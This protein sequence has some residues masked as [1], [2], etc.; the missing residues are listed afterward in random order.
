[1]SDQHLL[2]YLTWLGP[3]E[4]ERYQRFIRPQRQRQ[5]LLGRIL[6]R[7][8]LGQTLNVSP[9]DIPLS[10]RPGSAP[11]LHGAE[12]KPHFSLSHSGDWVACALSEQ[13]PVGLDIEVLNPQRDLLAL[14]EQALDEDETA[15]IWGLQ[16]EA[17]VKMFYACWSRKEALYKLTS[18]DASASGQHCVNLSHPDISIVL[19]SASALVSVPTLKSFNWPAG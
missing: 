9:P 8:L 15:L 16:G 18:A 4:I 6:L 12:A 13:T 7:S 1:M 14:S 11:L 3:G 19:C 10:E 5:F 17:R 2:P